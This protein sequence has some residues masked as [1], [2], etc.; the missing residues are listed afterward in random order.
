[1]FSMQ[2]RLAA[3]LTLI[4]IF[5]VLAYVSRAADGKPPKDSLYQ[6]GTPLGGFSGTRSGS[7]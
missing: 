2:K 3:W 1:M 5:I 4:G 7:G 6:Y